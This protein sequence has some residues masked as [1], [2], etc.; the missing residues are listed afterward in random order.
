MD[1]ILSSLID[2]LVSGQ[3]LAGSEIAELKILMND[4]TKA[5][6]LEQWLSDQWIA[7]SSDDLPL[8]YDRLKNRIQQ[9]EQKNTSK[10]SGGKYLKLFVRY[11]QQVAAVLL[12]P[13]VLGVLYGLFAQKPETNIFTAAAPMGQKAKV[14][15]PDGSS[16]W[17][18]SGSQITYSSDY[19][20]KTRDINL[21]GE[22]YFDVAKDAGKPFFVR[23]ANVDIEVTGTKFNLNA[24]NDEA[25]TET[26]LIEGHVNLY[27]KDKENK[28]YELKAGNVIAYSGKSNE[29]STS[30]LD[31]EAA[32]GWKDD[33]LIF[34]NDDFFK[35]ARKIERWY[36]MEV[37]YNPR[38]FQRNKL[39]VKLLEGEQLNKLLQIIESAVGAQCT[40]NGSK[41]YITKK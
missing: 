39:T 27:L 19:N 7:A 3:P 40:V 31:R 30:T 25:V 26:S 8:N 4:H 29:I 18:N 21:T 38:D 14:E 23:T 6:E 22:A 24:Y 28:K 20:R 15:L 11:Y 2:K 36:N 33:R 9:Y 34:I 5:K 41:I 35:L 10:H 17:L 37:V 32:I 1:K 12:I 13:L 16:V